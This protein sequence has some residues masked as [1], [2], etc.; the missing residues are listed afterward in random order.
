MAIKA[1]QFIHD[2]QGFVIDRI[3]TGGVSN[4]GIPQTKIYETGNYQTV[5]T[6]RDIP[7]LSFDI[8]SFDVSTEIEALIVGKDPTT[9]TTGQQL[10]F[11]NSIPM[12][13]ISPFTAG[14]G[15]FNVI[16]GIVVPY[17]TVE[18][19]AYTMG[20]GQEAS[21]KFT[22]RGDSLYYVPGSPYF[23]SFSLVSGVGPYTLAHTAIQYT[24]SG[25]TFYVLSACV[26]NPSTGAYRRLF[27]GT[28]AD[29]YSST[30]TTITTVTNWQTAGYTVMHVTYGS[31]TAATYNQATHQG[32]SVKPAA[33][34]P[35][36]ICVYVSDGAATPTLGKWSGVQNFSV[37]RSVTLQNNEEFCN[38]KYVS[39]DYDVATV[40]GSIGVKDVDAA[41]LF[42]KV[43]QVANVATNVV[44][45]PF[46]SL[47][48]EVE[49]V[50]ND[51][52]TGAAVKT[53]DIP[54]A[55]FTIPAMQA[56]VQTKLEVTFPFD[57][58]GGTLYVYKGA[59]P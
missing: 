18:S 21:E 3:Q 11:I 47:P 59:K 23:Q 50:I 45:G 33:V 53:L 44:V 37:T 57:S 28:S 10:D 29:G 5:A 30:S 7:D 35:K 17:L 58:D 41:T 32:V 36:D 48:L 25:S 38:S 14:S 9:I 31:A 6:I 1:A 43:A 54:D 12:D 52:D 34:R 24:E 16:E 27:H 55:R 15:A 2:A 26:K 22:F 56:K 8:D 49:V 19:A 46:S 39:I 51:P 20:I 40:S 42:S 13:V 4:L